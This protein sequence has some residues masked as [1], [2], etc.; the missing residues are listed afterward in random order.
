MTTITLHQRS[1]ELHLEL[2]HANKRIDQ[3][4]VILSNLLRLRDPEEGKFLVSTDDIIVTLET[5]VKLL[6]E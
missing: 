1:R 5:A 2:L 4:E 6:A 3:A